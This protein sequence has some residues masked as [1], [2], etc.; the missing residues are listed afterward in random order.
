MNHPP[1][2]RIHVSGPK[3]LRNRFI[4]HIFET[5]ILNKE[6]IDPTAPFHG[7]HYFSIPFFPESAGFV[8][9]PVTGSNSP[10]RFLPLG[11]YFSTVRCW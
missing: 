11:E 8:C 2:I 1:G 3:N 6:I 9:S 7:P 10:K 4:V 5:V